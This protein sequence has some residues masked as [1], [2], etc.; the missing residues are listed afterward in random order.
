MQSDLHT[1]L[2]GDAALQSLMGPQPHMDHDMGLGSASL[3][4]RMSL[5]VGEG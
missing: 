2:Y 3:P 5:S 1:T 4:E